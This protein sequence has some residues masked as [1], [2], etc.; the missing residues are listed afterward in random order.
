VEKTKE[1]VKKQLVKKTKETEKKTRI[2]YH[3]GEMYW[4]ESK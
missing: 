4:I 3:G 2:T 1:F